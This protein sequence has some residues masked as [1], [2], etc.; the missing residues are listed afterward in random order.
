[1]A[2]PKSAAQEFR[3]LIFFVFHYFFFRPE[4]SMRGAWAWYG[5]FFYCEKYEGGRSKKLRPESHETFN[6]MTKSEKTGAKILNIFLNGHSLYQFLFSFLYTYLGTVKVKLMDNKNCRW[7]YSYPG[8]ENTHRCGKYHCMASVQC[9]KF[10]LNCLTAYF[11]LF[12]SHS[13]FL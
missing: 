10:G 9:Y 4:T 2:N 5:A 7:L 1:M 11:F 8:S 12:W 13:L 6:R 3:G